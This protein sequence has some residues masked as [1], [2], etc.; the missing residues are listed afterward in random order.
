MQKP[1][2]E[3]HLFNHLAR[4]YVKINFIAITFNFTVAI[5]STIYIK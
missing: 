2:I 3:I 5:K 1:Y 4:A